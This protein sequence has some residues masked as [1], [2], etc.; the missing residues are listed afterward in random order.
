MHSTFDFQLENKAWVDI[1]VFKK[2]LSN[3]IIFELMQELLY[4]LKLYFLGKYK[5]VIL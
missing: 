4:Y 2:V 5:G 3:R 1:S